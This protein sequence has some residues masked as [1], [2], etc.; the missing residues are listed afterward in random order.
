MGCLLRKY[1]FVFLILAFVSSLCSADESSNNEISDLLRM[2]AI[3]RQKL[4][5]RQQ[6]FLQDFTSEVSEMPNE[7]PNIEENPEITSNGR[8]FYSDSEIADFEKDFEKT[9]VKK[10]PNSIVNGKSSQTAINPTLNQ[11]KFKQIL[12]DSDDAITNDP[13][14]YQNPLFSQQ[15]MKFLEKDRTDNL[16]MFSK[17]NKD[18]NLVQNKPEPKF[19]Q[20]NEYKTSK[21]VKVFHDFLTSAPIAKESMNET[22][23]HESSL[24]ETNHKGANHSIEQPQG[25][26]QS[27]DQNTTISKLFGALNISSFSIEDLKSFIQEKLN[28]RTGGEDTAKVV[29]VIKN[30]TE[31][32]NFVDNPANLTQDS[33]TNET[34]KIFNLSSRKISTD[35]Q[36]V[37]HLQPK[38]KKLKELALYK[39]TSIEY[40]DINNRIH[41]IMRLNCNTTLQ[42]FE[43]RD[44]WVFLCPS[45]CLDNFEVEVYGNDIYRDDSSICRAATHA[46]NIIII[47]IDKIFFPSIFIPV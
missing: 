26:E 37:A 22:L 3:V 15:Q 27:L 43:E 32:R 12:P 8:D 23:I 35:M 44:N 4:Y 39:Q 6:L 14:I 36:Y 10:H 9:V 13:A 33:N 46:G 34:N 21:E 2:K 41:K 29:K 24:L 1:I 47:C 5:E 28:H 31:T 18:E 45:R 42:S 7:I 17:I 40:V 38:K 25:S 16:E 19:S 30:E 20:L 11:H